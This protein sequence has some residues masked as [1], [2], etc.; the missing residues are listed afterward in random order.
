MWITFCGKE[1]QYRFGQSDVDK[2]YVNTRTEEWDEKRKIN[3]K[4]LFLNG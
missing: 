3:K 1:K 4:Q 2:S